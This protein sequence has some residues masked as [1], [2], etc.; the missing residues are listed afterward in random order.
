MRTCEAV[1]ERTQRLGVRDVYQPLPSHPRQQQLGENG[2]QRAIVKVRAEQNWVRVA[3][4]DVKGHALADRLAEL[5]EES[6]LATAAASKAAHH[7]RAR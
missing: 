4:D 2:E 5:R 3:L 7:R 1:L 6:R